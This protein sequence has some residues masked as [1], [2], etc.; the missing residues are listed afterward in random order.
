MNGGEIKRRDD[1]EAVRAN[2]FVFTAASMALPMRM[3][4]D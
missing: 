1:H 2:E 3:T 4:D